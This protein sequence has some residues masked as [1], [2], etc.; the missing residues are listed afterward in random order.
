MAKRRDIVE[1]LS[2]KE[3]Y[4]NSLSSLEELKAKGEVS[5]EH[6]I[7]LKNEYEKRI[8]ANKVEI[9]QLKKDLGLEFA[10]KKAEENIVEKQRENLET[11]V[12][13]GEI[14]YDAYQKEKRKLDRQIERSEREVSNLEMLLS[15]E[16]ASDI[17]GEAGTVAESVEDLESSQIDLA[18]V[19]VSPFRLLSEHHHLFVPLGIGVVMGI[20]MV[21]FGLGGP[22]CGITEPSKLHSSQLGTFIIGIVT[23]ILLG[24]VCAMFR[25]I[26]DKGTTSVESS[27]TVLGDKII[28]IPIAAILVGVIV[29]I[30]LTFSVIFSYLTMAGAV[31]IFLG[32]VS[33]IA[34]GILS[35]IISVALYCTIPAIVT[36]N[37]DVAEGIKAS[38]RFCRTGKNFWMLFVLVFIAGLVSIIPTI[39]HPISSFILP[40]WI[41]YAYIGYSDRRYIE[42]KVFSEEEISKK[43]S[44]ITTIGILALIILPICLGF[45]STVL[46]FSAME[47]AIAHA[48]GHYGDVENFYMIWWLISAFILSPIVG[49]IACVGLIRRRNWGYVLS[50]L[51]SIVLIVL[52]GLSLG[53]IH[54]G[55][56]G[57]FAS[58]A[59][60]FTIMGS[61][62][63]TIFAC[64]LLWYLSKSEIKAAF[65]EAD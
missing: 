11:R 38:W 16:K 5:E 28:S 12:K 25:E 57:E 51:I 48:S 21:I 60:M 58:G 22:L 53:A 19:V 14:G 46:I 39:G 4:E 20:I 65:M 8:T 2:E 61:L 26:K 41:G 31:D 47:E 43:T 45:Q 59:V 33:F 7:S 30:P 52:S 29:S 49:I 13:V 27:L 17:K 37:S 54:S 18:D 10:S 64:I 44:S 3:K 42:P 50:V 40:L 24:W 15:A 63:P 23:S 35:I 36:H 62:I 32:I 55:T 6:Y 56:F 1:T 9:Q 34:F